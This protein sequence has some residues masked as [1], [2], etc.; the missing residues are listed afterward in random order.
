MANHALLSASAA[1][2]WSVCT[3]SALLNKDIED[4]QSTYAEEGTE[5]HQVCEYLV[6]KEYGPKM[7]DPTKKLKHYNSEMQECADTYKGKIDEIVAEVKQVDPQPTILVEQRVDCS[8]WIPG[9]FGTAD[10]IVL[11]E[12]T[13]HICDYK[14]GAGIL[15]NAED[16]MQMKC[17]ALGVLHMFGEIVNIENICM[18]IIQPRKDNI[19]SWTTSVTELLDWGENYLKPR[20]QLAMKGEGDFVSGP[21]CQFCKVK[22]TC[23]KRAEDNLAMAKY[24]F[25]MP[26]LL[27]DTE[28]A[29]ILDKVDDLVSWAGDVKDFA[30][31][32]ALKGTKYPGY[33]VVA[34]RSTRKFT[35]EEA[36]AKAVTEA[37]FN[38]FEQRLLGITAMTTLLGKTKFEEL[39]SDYIEKPAGKPV[40]VSINDKRPEINSALED[41]GGQYYEDK[42]YNRC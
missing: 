3:P 13:T 39:L 15:V 36:V 29:V 41:F 40:L 23:R 2:R 14:H 12:G 16:N 31:S 8:P 26:D 33:K 6:R 30:L 42:S 19:S 20:A 4:I 35:D 11:A 5:A 25:Q 17:Y 7:R 28:I 10:C 27:D 1:Y 18:H 21:H 34:G 38:P 37:G 32:Q 9:G 24:D 22:A